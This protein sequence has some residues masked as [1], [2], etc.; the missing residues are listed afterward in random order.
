[1]SIPQ[2]R[3][4]L[5]GNRGAVPADTLASDLHVPRGI[6]LRPLA[7]TDRDALIR[8][9]ERC[10]PETRCAR[11]HEPLTT[12]PPGW[13]R[14]MCTPT[15]RRVAVAAV[16]EAVEHPMADQPGSALGAPYDDEVVGMVHIEPEFG[17][18]AILAILVEDAYQRGGLG[19]QLIHAALSAAAENGL[20]RVK[21]HIL[22]DNQGIRRLLCSLG[23]PVTRGHDDGKECWTIDASG[24]GTGR[25]ATP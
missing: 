19:R 24:L 3:T 17:R 10:S 23:L 18:T 9:V 4:A 12:L 22:L 1:V 5:A 6:R 2:S 16:V 20:T 21:C 11:F 8:T 7:A 13:A 14:S 25:N 15:G